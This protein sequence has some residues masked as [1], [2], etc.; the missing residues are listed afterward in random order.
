[1]SWSKGWIIL[2]RIKQGRR[3]SWQ[4]TKTIIWIKIHFH[5]TFGTLGFKFC[6]QAACI[7]VV[8]S[9]GIGSVALDKSVTLPRFF[10]SKT[11]FYFEGQ[12]TCFSHTP[13]EWTLCNK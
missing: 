12:L 7:L 6:F 9:L 1:M 11:A 5:I 2:Q 13:G 3:I 4:C 10:E 8:K